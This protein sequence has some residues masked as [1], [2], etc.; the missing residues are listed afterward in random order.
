MTRPLLAVLAPPQTYSCEDPGCPVCIIP[1]QNWKAKGK[2]LQ[3]YEFTSKHCSGCLCTAIPAKD[4]GFGSSTSCKVAFPKC[5][6]TGCCAQDGN[7]QLALAHLLENLLEGRDQAAAFQC[8]SNFQKK[9]GCM[10]EETW[11][12]SSFSSSLHSEKLPVCHSASTAQSMGRGQG[13]VLPRSS[14]QQ[15]RHLLGCELS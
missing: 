10:A 6:Y 7:L 2:K 13:S 11:K 1:G 3:G 15:H 4:S 8:S 14:G 12:H 5:R 9:S